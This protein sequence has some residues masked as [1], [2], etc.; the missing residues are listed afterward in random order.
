MQPAA[1]AEALCQAAV[2]LLQSRREIG[3]EI[4]ARHDE[5]TWA[6][7]FPH[8]RHHFSRSP[9][10]GREDA[11][12]VLKEVVHKGP[13]FGFNASAESDEVSIVDMY[14][15][16]ILDPVKVTRSC[17]EN[18]ASAAAVLL[19]TEAAVADIP[20]KKAAPAGPDM[21]GEIISGGRHLC[22]RYLALRASAPSRARRRC[23]TTNVGAPLAV[24]KG[25]PQPRG[26]MAAHCSRMPTAL[27]AFVVIPVSL[28]LFGFAGAAL[29]QINADEADDMCPPETPTRVYKE[30][31]TH[32]AEFEEGGKKY[33]N[34]YGTICK[35]IEGKQVA[36]NGICVDAHVCQATANRASYRR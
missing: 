11:A 35:D 23:G 13:A 19:T 12:V 16:G 25:F 1:I 4:D 15:A 7:H 22:R 2:R 33:F 30:E 32:L 26:Q 14:E 31:K 28:I 27:R 21:G 24:M 34:L 36:A 20:E 17:V 3:K 6:T 8:F 18:A 5:Y 9:E 29:A 10:C